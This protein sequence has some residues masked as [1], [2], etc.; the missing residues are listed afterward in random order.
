[1]TGVRIELAQLYINTGRFAEA[2][3]ELQGVVD[4]P[5]PAD[6]PRWTLK[7]APRARAMLESL[8]EKP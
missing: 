3:Q 4:E 8:R 7:E 2:R 5:A 1:M 6:R